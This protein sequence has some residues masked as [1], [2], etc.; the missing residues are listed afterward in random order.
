MVRKLTE[1][2]YTDITI[3]GGDGLTV[4]YESTLKLVRLLK[5]KSNKNNSMHSIYIST[6]SFTFRCEI[7]KK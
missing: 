2:P 1:N 4:Q 7:F 6:F 3:S 5:E